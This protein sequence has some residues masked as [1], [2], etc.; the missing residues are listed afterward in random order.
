M[1]DVEDGILHA[2]DGYI[3]E[4]EAMGDESEGHIGFDGSE[5]EEDDPDYDELDEHGMPKN[6]FNPIAMGLKEINGL[7]HFRVSSHKPGNGVEELM[8][9]DID[10]Y[11]QYVPARRIA[12]GTRQRTS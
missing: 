7:A 2:R 8:N 12:F 9:D 10:R 1:N 11:W 4:D 6:P 5:D 3:D